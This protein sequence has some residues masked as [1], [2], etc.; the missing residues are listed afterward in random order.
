MPDTY[1]LDDAYSAPGSTPSDAPA[2]AAYSLDDAYAPSSPQP[3]HPTEA[4]SGNVLSDAGNFLRTA[5]VKA[6]AG[7]AGLMSQAGAGGMTGVPGLPAPAAAQ[8]S[9][10]VPQGAIDDAAF[11]TLGPEYQPSSESGRLAMA[12]TSGALTGAA[13]GVDGLLPMLANAARG[14]AV[15]AG[16]QGAGDAGLPPWV[17]AV[18]APLLELLGR[19]GLGAARVGGPGLATMKQAITAPSTAGTNAAGRVLTGADNTGTALPAI[20]DADL[21]NAQAGVQQTTAAIADQGAPDYTVGQQIR[22]DLT[23]RQGALTKARSD[24]ADASY[25]AFRAQPPIAAAKLAPFMSSPSFRGAIRDANSAVLDEGESPISEYWTYKPGNDLPVAVKDGA[26]PPTVLDRVRTQLGAN[27]A[28]AAQ[29]GPAAAKTA[30]TLAGNFDTF[31]G[32]AYPATDTY[33]GYAAIRD[34]F[35]ANSAPLDPLNT[36]APAQVLENNRPYGGAPVYNMAPERVPDLFLRGPAVKTNLDQLVAAYGG[37]KG[38]AEG[39]LTQHLAGVAS[40]AIDPTTGAL[41]PQ[42][43][44]RVMQPYQKALNAN[45]GQWFPQLRQNFADAQSAQ[46]TLDTLTAQKGIGDSIAANGLRDDTGNVT[47]QSF[48]GWLSANKDAL[49]QAQGP[50]AVA[51]LQQ[52][53]SA[54]KTAGQGG[55]ATALEDTIPAAVGTLTGGADFGI[56]GNMIGGK[57]VRMVMSP[58]TNKYGAAFNDA[59]ENAVRDPAQARSL[60]AKLPKGGYT[61]LQ[62][63]KVFGSTIQP[64]LTTAPRVAATTAVL[65]PPTR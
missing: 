42:Q 10:P 11:N 59:I 23:S 7:V 37:D 65:S 43:F 24:A 58:W 14:A 47:A 41:N 13:T 1:S 52:I 36:G 39:A 26:I 55:T 40:T 31:L 5:A 63:L 19:A 30:K 20:S 9:G 15:G 49:T 22:S 48:N 51:R 16:S 8:P 53:G 35:K 60:V 45:A 56:L 25:D 44:A 6:G 46:S 62:A 28:A 17:G 27:V 64:A 38:A 3:T 34:K 54:L 32:S 57:A 21:A 4:P 33:P 50:Q 18:A 2:P 29:Q 12:G 61:P